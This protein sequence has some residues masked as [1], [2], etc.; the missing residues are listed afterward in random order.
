[1]STQD[2]LTASLARWDG[3]GIVVRHD[4]AT[5]AWIFI[6]LHDDTLGPPTGGTRMKVYSSPGQA[7]EDAKRLA[8]GMTAKFA[9]IEF[10]FGGAKAVLAVPRPLVGA[11]RRGLLA[12][13]GRLIAA[14]HGGF[15]TGPDLGTTAED[16]QEIAA[17]AGPYVHGFDPATGRL[18]NAGPY[19]ARGVFAAILA[20]L[21]HRFGSDELAGRRILIEGVGAVGVPLARQ[22]AA[23]GAELLLADLDRAAADRL[24]GETGGRVIATEAVSGTACDVY[25]PCAVGATLSARTIPLLACAI[26]AGS[27]NNQLEEEADALRLHARGILYAPDYVAN[28]GGAIGFGMLGR[29]ASE[30]E[31]E[32]RLA[33]VGDSLTEIFAEAAERQET[34]LLAA[35]RRVERVLAQARAKREARAEQEAPVAV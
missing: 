7:L 24:A 2:D 34:P 8:A 12:R 31:I 11:E 15:G 13:Y 33:G 18:T 23:G 26:V 22:L 25:A 21:R 30:T 20:A 3:I 5:G 9:A 27:A 29:G 19:T 1:M 17:A 28:A 16:M 4:P 32:A 10:P 14:L 35:A 6:A